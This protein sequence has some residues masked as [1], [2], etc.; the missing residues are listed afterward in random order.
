MIVFHFARDLEMF[1]VLPAGTTLTGGWAVFA[2]LIAG[3][4]LFIAG[5]SFVLAHGDGLRVRAWMKRLVVILGAACLISISTFIAFPDRFIYFGILHAIGF[6]SIVGLAF[7]RAPVWTTVLFSCAVL[8]IDFVSVDPPFQSP[9]LAWTGLS[10][11]V[12]PTL[13]FIP[14]IPWLAAFLLGMSAAQTLPLR[15]I[16]A[17]LGQAALLRKLTWPGRHSLA[18]YLIHQPVLLGVIWVSVGILD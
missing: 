5:L 16:G 3:S 2:R 14:V 4:F 11:S 10:S 15:N 8:A 12:R 17:S 1:G 18:V 6:A 9:W 13:D 7:L